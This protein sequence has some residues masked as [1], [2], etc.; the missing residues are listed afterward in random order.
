M[1]KCYKNLGDF[2]KALEYYEKGKKYTEKMHPS[3]R[4]N[5]LNRAEK[6]IS[7][8]KELSGDLKNN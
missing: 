3:E 4:G 8:I 7:E 1:G 6:L 2:E 5:Y